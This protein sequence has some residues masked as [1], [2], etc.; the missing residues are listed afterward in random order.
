MRRY[1]KRKRQLSGVLAAVIMGMSILP[2]LPPF[3]ACAAAFS[4]GDTILSQSEGWDHY[5]ID[6]FELLGEQG[7]IL[8]ENELYQY[9]LPSTRL[10]DTD[11]AYLFWGMLS[12]YYGMGKDEKVRAA[13]EQINQQA[14]AMGI[15]VI[16][17][18]VTEADLKLI[19]H[20]ASARKKYPWLE[21]AAKQGEKYLTAAGLLSAGNGSGGGQSTGI[22]GG[23]IPSVLSG[24]TD[25]SNAL[26]V[27]TESLVLQFDNTGADADFIRTVP[28][29]FSSDGGNWT[30][31]PGGGWTYQKTD[32]GIMFSN[33]NPQPP[34]LL[35]KFKT[36]NTAYSSGGGSYTSVKD[37]YDG[38]LQLWVCVACNNAHVIHP[39]TSPLDWHQRMARLELSAVPVDYYAAVAGDFSAGGEGGITF[40]IYRHEEQMDSHYNVQ[41][42]KY[43][44]ETGKPLEN[45]SFALYE[46]F[47]DKDQIDQERDGA[48]HLYEG[49]EPYKSYHTDDPVIWEDF[50][51]VD[52]MVTDENGHSEKTVQHGYHYD[53][54]FC[55]GHP[56]PVFVHV[57]EEEIDEETGEVENEA[58]IA[59]AQAE[60]RRLAAAWLGC[61]V[62]CADHG[63]GE[64]SGVHFHWVMEAVKRSGIERAASSGGEPG[65]TPDGGQTVSAGGEESY[66]KSG[67]RQDC[68]ATYQK[69]ISLRYSYALVEIK[70]RDGYVLHDIHADDIPIE[71]ITTDS[72]E[73]GANA[74][75]GG[76][77][78]ND[79]VVTQTTG[80]SAAQIREARKEIAAFRLTAETSDKKE[81]TRPSIIQTLGK[82][83]QKI[84]SLFWEN[85]NEKKAGNE[86][87]KEE[88]DELFDQIEL[89]NDLFDPS[90][91]T[92]S[93]MKN[94]SNLATPSNLAASSS[95]VSPSSMA[96]LFDLATPSDLASSSNAA[97]MATPSNLQMAV[98]FS[99]SGGGEEASAGGIASFS[100][101][102][103]NGAEGGM[104]FQNKYH[105]ALS[106]ASMGTDNTPGP[107]DKFS[108]CSN[109]DGE[110]NAWRIYDHRTEGE[111]HINKR[112]LDLERGETDKTGYDSYGDTQGDGT[113]EGAV[114]GLFAAEDIVHP[115][116]KT[117]IVYRAN[118]L[119]A[120]A[121]TDKNGDASFLVYT[122]GPGRFYHY[123]RGAIEDTDDR[124]AAGH[125]KNLYM[126]AKTYNDYTEDGECLTKTGMTERTYSDYERENGNCWIG[127]PLIMGDYYVKELTRSEGYELSIGN[128]MNPHTN[129]GQ[130]TDLSIPQGEGY[131]SISAAPRG[132]GQIREHATGAYGDPD[133]NEVFF[134]VQSSGTGEKGFDLVFSA[135]PEGT[136]L[137]RRETGRK[138]VPAPI[139][140]GEYEQ[141]LLTNADGSPQYVVAKQD[142]QYPKYQAD[143]SLMTEEVPVNGVAAWY[144]QAE[145]VYL[146]EIK[147]QEALEAAEPGMDGEA[148][149]ARLQAEFS[150]TDLNFVKGKTER[151]LRA[152]GK[153]TP[154]S[155]SDGNKYSS[156]DTGVYDAGVRKGET[157]ISGISGADPGEAAAKTVYGAPVQV[158]Q[159]SKEKE[160]GTALLVGDMILSVLDYY[161]SHAYFSYGGIDKIVE[162]GDHYLVTVYTGVTGGESGF[163]VAGDDPETDAVIYKAVRY[164]PD[165]PAESP[166]NIW[167]VYTSDGDGED[168][169]PFGRW[170]N[171]SVTVIGGCAFAGADLITDAAASGDGTLVTKTV[172]KNV[173]YQTGEIPLDENGNKIQAFEYREKVI[174]GE[175]ETDDDRW[176]ELPVRI[177]ESAAVHIDSNYT[178][179]FGA[180][181]EDSQGQSYDFRIVLPKR[182]IVLTE[183]DCS[184]LGENT[185]W[186]AGDVMAASV[187]Y[188]Q[189]KK[190][191]VKAYLDFQNQ[192][193]TGENSYIK[194]VSLAY[195]GQNYIWQDGKGTPGTNTRIEPVG[196]QERSIRQKI[197][198]V[199]D[200][201]KTSYHN[202]NSYSQVHEDW[203]TKLFGGFFGGGK[204]ENAASKIGN[205][206][207]KSY[208]KSNLE[209]IYR[210]DDGR[211]VW[212][213]RSGKEIEGNDVGVMADNQAFPALVRK[214]YTKV[215]HRTDPLYQ[216]SRDA[217]LANTQLYS[218]TEGLINELPN[219]GY[220]A[221]LETV[222]QTVEDHAGI[223]TVKAY[224]YDK[225]FDGIAAANHD[226]WD[227]GAPTYTSWQPIGNAVG[228]TEDTIE[229]AQVSDAVR[230]FAVDWYLDEEVKK[231]VKPTANPAEAE[232]AGGKMQYSDELYD[233]ALRAAIVKAENYL[234]PFYTY[235]LD[236]IY[237]VRWDE[238]K[239]GGSDQDQSTLSAD[240]LY[241]PGADAEE[242]EKS[243]GYYYGISAYLPYGTYVVI[244]QQPQY[245]DQKDFANKHY[246]TD[247]PKEVILPAVYTDYAGSQASPEI[248][249]GYYH[250]DA[251]IS[252]SEMERKYKIRFHEENR[253]IQA[254]NSYGDFDVFP[255][256][257]DIDRIS[258]GAGSTGAGDYFALTQAQYKPY[259]NYYNDQDDRTTG[260]V[261]YYLTEGKSGRDGISKS[262]RFSS[263]SEH[264][265]KADDV[266]YTGGAATDDNVP[267]IWY[268]DQVS[269]MHGVQTAFDG[270]YA[271]MLV[272]W[273]VTAPGR[274]SEKE[275]SKTGADGEN[276]Y[277]G[278][279]YT[280][281]RNRFY[282][283]K[284]RLE[285]LDSETHENILHDSGVFAIYAAKREDSLN[286]DGHVLFYEEPTTISGTELFL[287]AMGAEDIRP[288][289]RRR[290]FWDRLTGKEYG[291]GNLYTGVVPA[292]TPIC[293]EGERVILGDGMGNQTVAFKSF[294]TVLDGY[295]KQ[296]DANTYR[297]WQYQTV[298]YLETPQPLGA[299][300]YVILEE[301]APAGYT[302][303]KPVAVEVYS[304]KVTYYKEGNK[305]HRVLAALY[306][307]DADNQTA[308]GTK[309]QDT[310]NLARVNIENTPIKLKVEKLKESSAERED[311]ADRKTVTYKVSGRIDGNLTVIGGRS[312]YVYAYENGNYLGYA[313]KKGTLEYLASRKAAGEQVE[314][315]FEGSVFAGYGYVT[316]TLE[317][318][319][320]ENPYVTGAVMT[321]FEGLELTPSGDQEDHRYQ[322]LIVERNSTNNVTRMYVK[323]GYAGERV[324]FVREKD[325]NGTEYVT[326]YPVGVDAAGQPVTKTGNIWTAVTLPRHDTDILCYDLDNLEIFTSEMINGRAITYGYGRKHEKIALDHLEAEK[327][328]AARTDTPPAIY[329]FRGGVPYLEFVG[330]DFRKIRYSSRNKVITT[331]PE[332]RI[333]HLDQ[334]GCR[335]ALV[336]P[337]TGMAYVTEIV[338][339]Q[340]KILVWPVLLRRDEHGTII[341]RDKITTSR[342]ATIGENKDGYEEQEILEVTNHSGIEILEQERPSYE[343]K[344]SGYLTGSWDGKGSGKSHQEVTVNTGKGG[345]N[346]NG[347]VLIDQNNGAFEKS[348]NPVLDEH[349]LPVY[350]QR[351]GE[352][353]EKGTNLYDRN[354]EFVRYQDSDNLEEYNNNAYHIQDHE[355]LY[356]GKT[357]EE[358]QEQKKLYHRLGEG[359][360]LENTWVTSDSTPNDPFHSQMTDGQPD[361]LKRVPAGTYIMEE[362]ISPAGYLKGMPTGITVQETSRLQET[363]MTDKT[364]KVEIAKL[365][366]APDAAQETGSYRFEQVPG[367]VLALYEAKRVYTNDLDRYPKGYYLEKTGLLP[368]R[369]RSTEYTEGEK[370]EQIARWLTRKNPVYTEGI[371]AG[372]YLLEELRTP[373][374]FVTSAPVEVE[375]ENTPEVQTF[376]MYNDHTKVEIE[377]Y[378]LDG[379]KEL[380]LAGAEFAL[381]PAMVDE[382]G[383]VVY[384]DGSPKFW[385]DQEIDRFQTYDRESFQEFLPAFEAAYREYGAQKGLLVRWSGNGRDHHAVCEQVEKLDRTLAGGEETRF[386]DR[387]VM[388]MRTGEGALIRVSVYGQ[389]ENRGGRE[390]TFEYQFNYKKLSQINEYA[391]SYDTLEGRHRLDYLP[392]GTSYVLRETKVPHGFARAEDVVV[393]VTNTSQVHHFRVENQEGMLLVSKSLKNVDGE[394]AG[395]HLALYRADEEGRLV[396][397][398]EYLAADWITGEDGVYTEE[399]EINR[400][401]PAGFQ[402]GDLKPHPVRRLDD[403]I[404]WLVELSS[405]DYCNT[406]EPVRVEY[407]QGDE[408]RVVRT[409]DTMAEGELKLHKTDHEGRPLAGA[410]FELSAYS[411][412]QLRIP[413]FTK[414]L[415]GSEA[416]MGISGL[417]VGEPG[418]GGKIVPYRYRLK[419]VV[420]PDGYAVNTE[421]FTWQ[422]EPNRQGVS[423]E[424][425]ETAKKEI[426][427][428]NQKTR[429]VIGK[430]N[431]DV[432]DDPNASGAFV[433]GAELAVYEV[434]GRD[435]NDGLIYDESKPFAVWV[436]SG[437]AAENGYVAEGLVA[438]HSYLLKELKA[439]DGYHRM[440][441][442][443]FTMSQ[444]GRRI[445]AISNRLN[446]ITVHTIKAA[447]FAF[448]TDNPDMDSIQAVTIRGRYAVGVTYILTDQDGKEAARWNAVSEDHILVRDDHLT[449]GQVYTLTELTRYS[450]GSEAV[451]GKTTKAVWFDE[452]GQCRMP[453]RMTDSVM[454]TMQHKDGEVI[455]S[456]SVSEWVQEKT[457]RNNASAEN[458]KITM[459]NR[460]GRPGDVLDAR[461]AVLNTVSFVNSSFQTENIRIVVLVGDGTEIIDEG[462]GTLENGRLVFDIQDVEAFAAGT[463]SFTTSV[464]EEALSSTVTAAVYRDGKIR[465]ATKTVP[466]MQKN[467]LTIFN[468][469]TGSG[470]RLFAEE[471]SHFTVRLFH[472]K[473]GEELKGSYRYQGSR[474]GSIRSGDTLTLTGNEFVTID[475]QIYQNVRYEVVREPDGKNVDDN[476]INGIASSENGGFAAF[477]RDLPDTSERVLFQKGE[478]YVLT[479]TTTYT[480]GTVEE[481]SRM[482]ITLGEKASIE[483]I[484]ALDKKTVIKL[485]KTELSGSKELPG[486]E[487]ELRDQDGNVIEAWI[488][489][490]EPHEMEGILVP[491]KTYILS[492]VN[493]A[494]GYSYAEEISF[495]VN[496][497]G[498]AERVIMEDRPTHVTVEKT[499]SDTGAPVKGALLQ[500]LDEQGKVWESW[501]SGLECYEIQ[502]KLCAGH[503]YY[504]HEEKAPSG[505]QKRP[506]LAFTVP[507]YGE[508][509]E[510]DFSNDK[511]RYS[512]GS[513][514]EPHTP[515][516]EEPKKTGW[517][518]VRYNTGL[519]AVGELIRSED[520]DS[521]RSA[522]SG[523]KWLARTGDDSLT[524]WYLCFM[525]LSL[526]GMAGC[527]IFHHRRKGRRNHLSTQLHRIKEKD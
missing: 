285:K 389:Y 244:E 396:K 174:M 79:I 489:G 502:G 312:D 232:Y 6:S 384:Q 513:S 453:G 330:G 78:G 26:E 360:I 24:H 480:D 407:R 206:R 223:R 71:I 296:E 48:T 459:R 510:L 98:R 121:S 138:K 308:N 162:D 230:Q 192:N 57:P 334:D 313:W 90:L 127:R 20:S 11:M 515:K 263:V 354:D 95:V 68:E 306:E 17:K 374:G 400:R 40:R 102:G 450:D 366:G 170:E 401:I 241:E 243:G 153:H 491:G 62:A 405:P 440:Q 75:F 202:T 281:L 264:G 234:K 16:T 428:A 276:S 99:R 172:T 41:L 458:P 436:S 463:V 508:V 212:L 257:L 291:P 106:T 356:D 282:T 211:I 73:N 221:L 363:S 517:I 35:I 339:G 475:P 197:K 31:Q 451:T 154:R 274:T 254:H 382:E 152:S 186:S 188:L 190:L 145:M 175:Q 350:Y 284:L 97:N 250:Y 340:E 42:N 69:F 364:I 406:F 270:K 424:F 309:P 496:E 426:S 67:C 129:Y 301:K 404:Y 156:V 391:V 52:S 163:F 54:T 523:N 292:G 300:A 148:A 114:Y 137:Y 49:G 155:V 135:L 319:D 8:G 124:W 246:Q 487:M 329:A 144:P 133:V 220:T 388:M 180:V 293:E 482:Q 512:G 199:K 385:E 345:R 425:G 335:D 433:A 65:S 3:P 465:A 367:A 483:H 213:D 395:A 228:R 434:T 120:V 279:S 526:V 449:E 520:S 233:Q 34:R 181:H 142:G 266:P 203:W 165:D 501:V 93:N 224:N 72:S 242:N 166:R 147:V 158:L 196:V 134:S 252:H 259:K 409:E 357:M 107:D 358:E 208:L 370:N 125:P 47:D 479:E 46:R 410:V 506:D 210:D 460:N 77:Y 423:Y 132:E 167:A 499:D 379:E 173:Y 413:L 195:P 468:E 128:R 398:P 21:D 53:K 245:A 104:L 386:P 256:G 461:R 33:P 198:V 399:D 22:G 486:C 443:L 332:T 378:Y 349:G 417:P 464:E 119:A 56:A 61:E 397:Q 169:E 51:R 27:G 66:E 337:Y 490:K 238:E 353:Y 201:E 408:S 288:M 348:M 260:N 273:T 411:Q 271:S 469:L 235:D 343:H 185:V 311:A 14:A 28:L 298:G 122:E 101:G 32:T 12:F 393:T 481:S 4:T 45:S 371:P 58:E 466:V 511:V 346:L 92:P 207:F 444:D 25:I 13:I 439:P 516:P 81:E 118:N 455:D 23:R 2:H 258:N 10:S 214:I 437:D 456:L 402:K 477:T 322:G 336:D 91:S 376:V 392:A 164:M 38:C 467:C 326:E 215:L 191:Q 503:T 159:I 171:L 324:E 457:I 179:Q 420:P 96:S 76:G 36:A 380:P 280:K 299:G 262:Y 472:G 518:T 412:S 82:Y 39:K 524:G 29:A 269:T 286:G 140:T 103:G 205:F 143:G 507:L 117:G 344:E 44:H 240:L 255:Y 189:V 204:A 30:D 446:T 352:C 130:D 478:T 314:L 231:L 375:I 484:S 272:P 519:Q 168:P 494:P 277:R 505:Y 432:F 521:Q 527:L 454:L 287:K 368:F 200:I 151:A 50:R 473:T 178:D 88:D 500:I 193:L 236:E 89:I 327:A 445:A 160:D 150:M 429:V 418:P 249:N 108:H 438:G 283:A 15:S 365:D 115:D 341:S 476:R 219:E 414:V 318:A 522:R 321:L 177:E 9:V 194:T 485:S 338:D 105:E 295:M 290:S 225:F 355:K 323:E 217:V 441:P 237:A 435:E 222:E 136:K 504:L 111:I 497:D 141:V 253:V 390:F 100:G 59:A 325:E 421:V 310:V 268:R 218:Y 347:E 5:C 139:G 442:V 110:G 227:D 403:G 55:D 80:R 226:K 381:Y 84:C 176:A 18:H 112:D 495:T 462:T 239:N 7:G 470:K 320:D 123:E 70:A 187:Y 60:N 109:T 315:A 471:E 316:R 305:D 265:G 488:S 275:D 307:Y 362:L 359:Y 317:T 261:P 328:N 373:A 87:E 157:D 1:E 427:V 452:N 493:P 369:Y 278:Y 37:A 361:V 63:S 431:F 304:D 247:R 419:E 394:L 131:V 387:A 74:V 126:A 333:Y 514:D 83:V 43:D 113:L 64:F 415:S 474:S 416:T 447:D 116:G 94:S 303:S 302:R 251:S 229:N 182:E 383:A 149:A 248:M 85:E 525:V 183:E 294:S 161:N 267:G 331:D 422:F 509:L 209:R 297:S 184:L 448:D 86:D 430:R 146:D 372:D 492:E 19:L 289:A 351:S 377:K 498:T 342:L 216:D